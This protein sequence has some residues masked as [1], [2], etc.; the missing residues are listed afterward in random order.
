MN[1]LP[2]LHAT[3]SRVAVVQVVQYIL[4]VIELHSSKSNTFNRD[5]RRVSADFFGFLLAE[6]SPKKRLRHT[7]LNSLVGTDSMSSAYY[8]CYDR[9]QSPSPIFVALRIKICTIHLPSLPDDVQ[10]VVSS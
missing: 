1:R 5:L 9:K 10:E 8:Y 4:F 2:Y 3:D 7:T 6:P